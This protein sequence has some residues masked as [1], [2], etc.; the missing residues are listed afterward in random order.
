MGYCGGRTKP[1]R[2]S[3]KESALEGRGA[4]K[5]EGNH[6]SLIPHFCPGLTLVTI[7]FNSIHPI[8]HFGVDFCL[9][10]IFELHNHMQISK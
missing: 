4:E 8:I 2:G 3:T 7:C 6:S 10:K 5:E 9:L 1:S